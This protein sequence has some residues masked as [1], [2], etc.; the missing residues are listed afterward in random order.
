MRAFRSRVGFLWPCVGL[1]GA[2]AVAAGA[3]KLLR[4]RPV[5]WWWQLPLPGGHLAAAH[6]FWAG[7]I[8]LCAAW[9]RVGAR[10]GEDGGPRRGDIIAIASLWALPLALGPALF[11]LDMYSYLAQGSLLHHGVNPY[12]TGPIALTRWHLGALLAT[13]SPS[14]RHT[15]T[16][17]GPLFTA[18]A[19]AIAAISGSHLTLGVTLMRIP[20]LAGLALAAVYVPRLARELGADPVRALWL[21]V[22]SPL[23]LLYL[24]GGGHNDAL[25]A[26]LVVAGVTLALQRRPLAAI[27]VCSL[28]ATV[29]LPA[30]A[31]VG[32]IGIC[33]LR[34]E[35]ERWRSIVAQGAALCGGLLALVG[36]LTGVGVGW[37]SG[38]MF[39][40]PQSVRIA[41][42]PATTLGAAVANLLYGTTAGHAAKAVE[43]GSV[44]LAV[45]VVGVLC[46][47]ACLRVSY[48][49]LAVYAG[50]LLV[51]AALLGP[52]AWPWYL[53]WG[54]VLLAAVPAAQRSRWLPVALVAGAFPVMPGGQVAT[55]LPEAPGMLL[56]YA[57][58]ALAAILYARRRLARLPPVIRSE[59]P[60]VAS[61]GGAG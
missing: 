2:L 7:V 51:A 24:V 42:T 30:L 9:L 32:L 48:E 18:L 12:H 50:G 25:M 52:A 56:I 60:R 21:T 38:S 8:V 17:Y 44:D 4:D 28:A 58:V 49:R 19:S 33:W 54:I 34:A 46:I 43:N 39:S 37:I 1:A 57:L 41:I 47:W 13:V 15:T 53:I 20:E 11:S 16:P 5:H 55:P 3:T 36:V 23:S 27:A 61:A 26:G 6:V 14:W 29:K 59:R 22:A 10:I 40:T 45:A 31:A 35:P